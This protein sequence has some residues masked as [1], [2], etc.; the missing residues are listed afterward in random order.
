MRGS[1]PFILPA[2]AK[3]RV[4]EMEA[5][6]E[7]VVR[8][9]RQ[10]VVRKPPTKKEDLKMNTAT[11]AISARPKNGKAEIPKAPIRVESKKPE[12]KKA[13]EKKTVKAY[14]PKSEKP[15]LFLKAVLSS[16]NGISMGEIKKLPWNST[17]QTFYKLSKK[18]AKL[19]KLTI[20]D[21]KFF[22]K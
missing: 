19:G 10:T 13:S 16:K 20:K 3:K 9:G 6:V 11:A 2:R 1:G 15:K 5:Q 14:E 18:M 22:P 21:G 17:N 7:K 8:N 12:P 4:R